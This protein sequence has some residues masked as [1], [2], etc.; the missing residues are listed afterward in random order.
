MSSSVK[1]LQYCEVLKLIM[2]VLTF[3]R[4]EEEAHVF[5]QC[6]LAGI[7]STCPGLCEVQ[8]KDTEPLNL[9]SVCSRGR[10]YH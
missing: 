7:Y 5:T 1:P 9:W 6:A 4:L 10:R 8:L 2:V 3:L